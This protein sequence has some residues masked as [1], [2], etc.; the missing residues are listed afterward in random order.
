[1]IIALLA[2]KLKKVKRHPRFARELLQNPD[3]PGL[4]GQTTYRSLLN[5]PNSIILSLHKFNLVNGV[6]RQSMVS[7]VN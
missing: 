7:N 3:P 5:F 6:N 2:K 4:L 1:M